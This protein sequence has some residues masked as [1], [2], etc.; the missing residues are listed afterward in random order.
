[1]KFFV[2]DDDRASVKVIS[3]IIF[4]EQLGEVIGESTI[5]TDVE[6]EILSTL[7]DL[8]IIDLLMPEQDGIETVLNLYSKNFRGKF[9]MISQV[10]NKEMVA[11]A[12]NV[13]IEFFIHKPINKVEVSTIIQK[14][15]KQLEMEKSL[16]KIKENLY[17]INSIENKNNKNNKNIHFALQQ[18][19]ADLGIL[20]DKGSK[21]LILIIEYIIKSKKYKKFLIEDVTLKEL[22][23]DVLKSKKLECQ[24]K[25]VKSLEQ[26]IRRSVNNALN[27]ISSFGLNDYAHPKFEHYATKY[28]DFEE[29]RLKMRELK[30]EKIS[31]VPR[32]NLKKFIHAIC[33]EIQDIIDTD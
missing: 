28:F 4:E 30:N 31:R 19:L 26:R 24:E 10:E 16:Q 5:S 2:I 17:N 23:I 32:I 20:G 12:Y 27:N 9:I 15:V 29:V 6:L 1:M 7:P 22:Y 25:D 33:I 21:D 13:G 11:K 3:R 18:I 8:V 14:V